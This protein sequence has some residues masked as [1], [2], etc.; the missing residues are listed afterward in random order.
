MLL[1][2]EHEVGDKFVWHQ[3]FHHGLCVY[4]KTIPNHLGMTQYDSCQKLE[5]VQSIQSRMKQMSANSE[6][7][8]AKKS[9]VKNIIQEDGIDWFQTSLGLFLFTRSKISRVNP[10]SMRF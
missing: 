4:I 6:L 8:S 3:T 10:R 7:S 1:M 9:C 2:L 5:S